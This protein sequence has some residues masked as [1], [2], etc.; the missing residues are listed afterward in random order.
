MSSGD[1][2]SAR[3]S[4]RRQETEE[5]DHRQAGEQSARGGRQEERAAQQRQVDHGGGRTALQYDE[6]GAEKHGRRQQQAHR[7]PQP[8]VPAQRQRRHQRDQ[9]RSERQRPGEVRPALPRRAR[10]RQ[11]PRAEPRHHQRGGAEDA[12]RH[13]PVGDRPDEYRAHGYPAAHEGTPHAGR[14]Q[15][16][17][18]SGEGVDEQAEAAGQQGRARRALGDAGQREQPG[19]GR[20]GAQDGGD[21][22]G[23]RA[24]DEEP[25]APVVV[26]QA[27]GHQEQGGEAQR[28]AVQQPGLG[29]QRGVQVGGRLGERDHRRGERHQGHGGRGAGQREGAARVRGRRG[30]VRRGSGGGRGRRGPGGRG[31]RGDRGRRGVR[32]GLGHGCRPLWRGPLVRSMN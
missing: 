25:A 8:P 9:R 18:R 5:A 32:A 16:P 22:E 27:A 21:A 30:P 24:G 1:R 11:G 4:T 12:V 7:R 29:G 19:R 23:Q 20:E 31:G 28:G 13:P 2:P 14:A 10:L 3:W 6:Q 17:G 15:P 26:G